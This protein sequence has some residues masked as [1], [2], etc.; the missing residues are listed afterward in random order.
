MPSDFIFT[1]ENLFCFTDNVLYFKTR[2]EQ[3]VQRNT[4]QRRKK[5]DDGK[6]S[7]AKMT[8]CTTFP[9]L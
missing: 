7:Q 4:C 8:I 1:K 2:A 6:P 5:R 3:K 9:K